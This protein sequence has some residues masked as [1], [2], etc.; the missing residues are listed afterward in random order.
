MTVDLSALK[1]VL[2]FLAFQD[3]KNIRIT[4]YCF[5]IFTS[6]SSTYWITFSW[7][8]IFLRPLK[9]SC[10][11]TEMRANNQVMW[12]V[13]MQKLVLKKDLMFSWS[14]HALFLDENDGSVGDHCVIFIIMNRIIV[15]IFMLNF[16]FL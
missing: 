12:P 13:I 4:S 15:C 14:S 2:W 6:P 7:T 5:F 8:F 16:I 1:Y 10:E 11:T 3:E 9:E